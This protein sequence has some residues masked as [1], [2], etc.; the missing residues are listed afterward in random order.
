MKFVLLILML[1]STHHAFAEDELDCEALLAREFTRAPIDPEKGGLVTDQIPLSAPAARAA[2][3]RGIFPW[4]D[5]VW[6]NPTERGILDFADL[7]ISTKDRKYLNRELA[8]GTLT[9]TEDKAFEQVL[10]ACAEQSRWTID[11]ATGERRPAGHWISETFIQTWLE[12][13]ATGNAHSVEVWRGD[14]LV[15]GL[16]V[17]VVDGIVTGESMFHKE[18]DVTKLA[19]FHLIEKLKANGHTFIDTQQALGLVLKWG[20]KYVPR[21]EYMR[22]FHE[23]R[24]KNLK[25]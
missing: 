7:H 25:F 24:E 19:F 14:Q 9:V 3:S 16:Y 6:Y 4:G 2:Y 11:R 21:D 13:H 1:L 18:E 15:G 8:A 12:L 20:G 5:N 22:R 23:A 10:R 17:T